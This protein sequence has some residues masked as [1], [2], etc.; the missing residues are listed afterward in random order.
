MAQKKVPISVTLDE[1]QIAWMDKEIADNRFATRT[2]ALVYAL[3]RLMKESD[4]KNEFENLFEKNLEVIENLNCKLLEMKPKE[5]DRNSELEKFYKK[6][7]EV[8]EHLTGKLE[9]ADKAIEIKNTR[10][11]K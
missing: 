7:L 4:R 5:S 1:D 10:L 6:N 8:L 3:S 9:K 2:H 11:R